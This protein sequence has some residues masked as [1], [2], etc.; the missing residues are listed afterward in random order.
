MSGVARA[1]PRAAARPVAPRAGSSAQKTRK[2]QR[3]KPKGNKV[4]PEHEL[5]P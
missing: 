5:H 4:R 3:Q 2:A 1:G